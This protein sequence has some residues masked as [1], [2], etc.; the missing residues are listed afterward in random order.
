MNHYRTWFLALFS[1]VISASTVHADDRCARM[2]FQDG[3]RITAEE[4]RVLDGDT[5]TISFRGQRFNVRFLSMDTPETHFMGGRS[6]GYWGERA[7]ERLQQLLTATPGPVEIE[8]DRIPCD[9]YGRLLG[10]IHKDGVDVNR[11]LL[12]DGLAI[13][14]CVFPTLRRCA[15]YARTVRG[16]IARKL[17]FHAEPGFELPYEFRTRE[18]GRNEAEFVSQPGQTVIL[19]FAQ[20]DQIPVANRIFFL[21]AADVGPPFVFPR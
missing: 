19:P 2:G 4:F 3:Q 5:I 17:G 11:Q 6:Q 20:R 18:S 12:A 9:I 7:K 8:F 13:N 21:R 15:L 10:Y 16:A 14:F 1:V